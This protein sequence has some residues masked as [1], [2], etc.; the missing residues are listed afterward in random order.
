MRTGAP[1]QDLEGYAPGDDPLVY[2]VDVYAGEAKHFGA[3][4]L[5]GAD[6]PQTGD[7]NEACYIKL[8]HGQKP[9]NSKDRRRAEKAHH[10]AIDMAKKWT[11]RGKPYGLY[12]WP[13][14][15]RNGKKQF[16]DVV[17]ELLWVMA[18]IIRFFKDCHRLGIP[19]PTL[20]W[21]VDIE[22]HK[23]KM[24]AAHRTAW[25]HWYLRVLTNFLGY[26]PLVYMGAN[27]CKKYLLD[28][29]GAYGP[30]NKEHG[31]GDF[32]LMQ[33][34]YGGRNNPDRELKSPGLPA[35]FEYRAAH[36]F[37]SEYEVREDTGDWDRYVVRMSAIQLTPE[38]VVSKAMVEQGVHLS[39]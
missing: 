27:Y 21:M 22:D 32:P 13:T 24:T 3:E 38:Q 33:P 34:H 35:E 6:T 1:P 14:I 7:D 20:M 4:L 17:Y 25:L 8:C 16:W 36:Q 15:G 11:D 29:K 9:D 12:G 19:Y 18:C 31:L 37:T 5:D 30:P 39:C 28:K 23:A 26:K 2:G 10:N